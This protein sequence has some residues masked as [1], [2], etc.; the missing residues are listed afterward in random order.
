MN[1]PG[2]HR[3]A[4]VSNPARQGIQLWK[5]PEESTD[6][7]DTKPKEIQEM[8]ETKDFRKTRLDEIMNATELLDFEYAKKSSFKVALRLAAILV[9][10]LAIFTM[11]PLL[12]VGFAAYRFMQIDF[13]TVTGFFAGACNDAPALAYA[14]SLAPDNDKASLAFATV[15]PLTMFLRILAAQL[16]ILLL[17]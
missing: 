6:Y 7:Y 9:V 8:T 3:E 14:M 1:K 13:F 5:T 2:K 16:M 10:S 11:L 12:L 17:C 4:C 15:Y